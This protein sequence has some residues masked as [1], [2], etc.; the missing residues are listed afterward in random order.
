MRSPACGTARATADRF[1]L[2]F[3]ENVH[4]G[5]RRNMLG[6]RRWGLGIAVAVLA[7]C[8]L[9]FAFTDGTTSELL[10]A[11]AWPG[12]LSAVMALFWWRVVTPDW[13][14]LPADAYADR[15][16]E[17][18]DALRTEQPSSEADSG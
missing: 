6:L 1:R 2:V 16:L 8:A 18:L 13:V 17:A 4:Y 9:A 7:I 14:R 10:R 5:F 12:A 15:L 3:E 11:W